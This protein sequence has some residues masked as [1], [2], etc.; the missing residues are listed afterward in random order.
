M[1]GPGKVCDCVIKTRY[2]NT[3][4]FTLVELS[5]VLVIIGLIVGGV[6]V[7]KDLIQAAQA[8]STV[9][10]ID[11]YNA[12]VHTF[13]LKYNC[14]PGDCKNATDYFTGTYNGNGD[15]IFFPDIDS[16][17]PDFGETALFWVHLSKA[18]LISNRFTLANDSS[19][20]GGTIDQYY[21]SAKLGG[22]NYF[23]VTTDFNSDNYFLLS[24]ATLGVTGGTLASYNLPVAQAF[25]IDTKIDD[26]FPSS[27]TIRALKQGAPGSNWFFQI[28]PD[29]SNPTA[30]GTTCYDNDGGVGFQLVY[31]METPS[32]ASAPNCSLSIKFQ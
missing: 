13:Q 5:I 27:G 31:S 6:L 11:G 29:N 26:G 18:N 25:S 19:D 4:G 12:A 23:F 16:N 32:Y 17:L 24:G 21:P 15:G 30:N 7:G 22:G 10:Q 14:L 8:R 1:K 28:N 3:R 20:T 2:R 9:A